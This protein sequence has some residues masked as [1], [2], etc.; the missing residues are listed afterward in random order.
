MDFAGL[1]AWPVYAA[2]AAAGTGIAG[3]ASGR[4][5]KWR[6]GRSTPSRRYRRTRYRKVPKRFKKNLLA[7]KEAKFINDSFTSSPIAANSAIRYISGTAQGDTDFTREGSDIYLTSIQGKFEVFNDADTAK[8]SLIK[9][10]LV[11]MVD[12]RGV[13][14][15]ADDLFETDTIAAMRKIDGSKNLHILKEWNIRLPQPVTAS[16]Q[17]VKYFKFFYK[18]KSALRVKYLG[19]AATIASADRNAIFFM[20][21]SNQATTFQP[22]LAGQLRVTFKD[23]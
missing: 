14:F 13:I 18:F 1:G 5:S 2:L 17:T 4:Y 7:L 12:V 20:T 22:S 11:K 6:A 3:H 9:V 21:M 8:D 19:T 23:V 16:D 15:A 10:L